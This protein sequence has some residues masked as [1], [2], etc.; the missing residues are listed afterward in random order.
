MPE[1]P[2]VTP[3]GGFVITSSLTAGNGEGAPTGQ[4]GG[5]L[6]GLY[7][8]PAIAQGAV[9]AAK[10]SSGQASSNLVLTANGNGGANWIMPP[11]GPQGP[12][13][14]AGLQGQMG[15]TGPSGGVSS[16]TAGTGINVTGS[17]GGPTV[18][19]N[20]GS[21]SG[22]ICQGNDARLSDARTPLPGSANY[23]QNQSASTQTGDFN[24]S[25]NGTVGGTLTVGTA[26]PMAMFHALT[27][28]TGVAGRVEINNSSN[29]NTCL[30][31]VTNGTGDAGAFFV[32]NPASG[33][34][35]VF[36]QVAG[37]GNCIICRHAIGGGDF[38]TLQNGGPVFSTVANIDSTGKANLPAIAVD[39][40]TFKVDR[41]LIRWS[42]S[43]TCDSSKI[44][45]SWIHTASV[46]RNTIASP[47]WGACDADLRS[48]NQRSSPRQRFHSAAT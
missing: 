26:T 14:P 30:L 47:E 21:I 10:I 8:N 18:S 20:F 34:D 48:Q 43:G 12:T 24:I 3:S 44:S 27:T 15:P 19:A 36:A 29:V 46:P 11:S 4:A 23:I 17:A 13:G 42:L 22:T 25:G 1:H 5:D 45:L 7:P 40:N 2:P 35:A 37:A 38:L 16:V 9:S 32:T 39:T 28:S 41:R 6:T 33:A 31:A